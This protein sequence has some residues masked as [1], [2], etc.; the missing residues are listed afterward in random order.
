MAA[1]SIMKETNMHDKTTDKLAQ[2]SAAGDPAFDAYIAARRKVDA[3]RLAGDSD[4]FRAAIAEC[5]RAYEAA[6]QDAA[7]PT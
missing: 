6:V 4:M 7:W 1:G 5:E 2:S 3:A